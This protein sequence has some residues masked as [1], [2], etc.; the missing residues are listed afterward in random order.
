MG[1]V[2][3][4]PDRRFWMWADQSTYPPPS[5]PE[6]FSD[7]VLYSRRGRAPEGYSRY[8]QVRE[9]GEG[10]GGDAWAMLLSHAGAGRVAAAS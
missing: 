5:K 7:M 10:E 9:V 3:V 2:I 8:V 1:S 4:D 6:S